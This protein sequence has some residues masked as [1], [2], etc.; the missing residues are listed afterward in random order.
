MK[1]LS[2]IVDEI[3]NTKFTRVNAQNV[4]ILDHTQT[5]EKSAVPFLPKKSIHLS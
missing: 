3:M 1:N 5:K 4:K 2:N